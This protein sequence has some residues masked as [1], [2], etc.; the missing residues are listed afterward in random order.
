MTGLLLVL[1]HDAG[2]A[3]ANA[4]SPKLVFERGTRKS[5][6]AAERVES[7]RAVSSAFD[8]QSSVRHSGAVPWTALKTRRQSLYRTRSG[9]RSLAY[10]EDNRRTVRI[11]ASFDILWFFSVLWVCSLSSWLKNQI[12]NQ[13]NDSSVLVL[14]GLPLPGPLS[15]RTRR[16]S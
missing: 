4:R 3:T 13:E 8:R 11:L 10:D 2:P 1:F 12:I 9:T 15:T 6:C 16:W 7:R 5:P 14:R